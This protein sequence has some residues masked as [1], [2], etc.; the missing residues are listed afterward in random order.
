MRIEF[1]N[2]EPRYQAETEG[3]TIWLNNCK[4]FDS[5]LLYFE[6]PEKKEHKIMEIFDKRLI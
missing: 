5:N 1:I 4:N 2:F 6:I 3:K